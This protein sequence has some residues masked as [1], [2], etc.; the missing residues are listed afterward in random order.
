M[1]SPVTVWRNHKNLRNYLGKTGK[2]LVWTKIYIAPEGFEHEAPYFVAIVKLE[3][4]RKMPLQ[5]VEC[6]E[7]DLIPNRKV[8]LVVRKLGKVGLDKVIEYGVKAKPL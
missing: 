7:K 8:T 2:V 3:D 5:M 6:E 4:G 1:S